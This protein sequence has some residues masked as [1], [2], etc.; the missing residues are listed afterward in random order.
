[1]NLKSWLS[2]PL[3]IILLFLCPEVTGQ[4]FFARRNQEKI[5]V[6]VGTG[7]TTYFGDLNNPGDIFD[8]RPNVNVGIGVDLDDRFSARAEFTWYQIS[9]ADEDADE[10]DRVSRNLSF[11][12]NNFELNAVGLV[13]L[14]KRGDRRRIQRFN[15]YGFGGV[16]VTLI[17]PTAELNGER[18]SLP[19]FDTENVDYSTAVLIIPFGG[20]FTYAFSYAMNLSIEAG[21]RVAFSDY[22]DDVSTVYPDPA[23]LANDI[24]RQLSDRRE[25]PGPAGS[26][27]GNP[28]NDD[29]YFILGLKLNY[30]ID[31][32]RSPFGNKRAKSRR[33]RRRRF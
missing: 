13:H 26:V 15:V 5:F 10:A 11:R 22:L 23:F 25:P 18:F 31:S 2:S 16:G 21:Y 28:D 29:A 33:Y 9:G 27:R 14:F 4:N 24:A 12:A 30:Y 8:A 6:T 3:L 19:D 20:G 32:N 17:N 1:M 7:V